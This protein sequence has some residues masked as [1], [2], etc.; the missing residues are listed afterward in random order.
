MQ[1]GIPDHMKPKGKHIFVIGQRFNAWE[2]WSQEYPVGIRRVCNLR[3]LF[4]SLTGGRAYDFFDPRSVELE[5][6]AVQPWL[7][8]YLSGSA[9]DSAGFDHVEESARLKEGLL[10]EL[11]QPG[12]ITHKS[13]AL[14]IEP[15]PGVKGPAAEVVPHV[16]FDVYDEA[17]I[18]MRDDQVQ[19]ARRGVG[20]TVGRPPHRAQISRCELLELIL[21]LKLDKQL[22]VERFEATVS[23]STVQ[24]II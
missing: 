20:D 1:M 23:Q 10:G 7:Q 6:K 21:F 5:G 14:P 3:V 22:P 2:S 19:Q 24:N 15:H 13:L 16:A 18:Y 8:P 17:A 4:P 9:T 11:I 12:H